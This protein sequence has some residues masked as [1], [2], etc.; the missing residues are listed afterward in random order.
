M[1]MTPLGGTLRLLSFHAA[2]SL[3]YRPGRLASIVLFLTNLGHLVRGDSAP[4]DDARIVRR[5]RIREIVLLMPSTL[6]DDVLTLGR[7]SRS[8]DDVEE[9]PSDS[10]PWLTTY[11]DFIDLD[12]VDGSN[13]VTTHLGIGHGQPELLRINASRQYVFATKPTESRRIVLGHG[14]P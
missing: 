1:V 5:V 10:G 4:R 7:I 3:L 11:H 6:A 14:A 12:S 2:S 9:L 8:L 13:G